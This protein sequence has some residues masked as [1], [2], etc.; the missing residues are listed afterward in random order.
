MGFQL[1]QDLIN[2]SPAEM[3]KVLE[4]SVK[5]VTGELPT[6][7]DLLEDVEDTSSANTPLLPPHLDNV[8]TLSPIQYPTTP[9]PPQNSP[10]TS[11]SS[12]LDELLADVQSQP[13]L[14]PNSPIQIREGCY[15][16]EIVDRSFDIIDCECAQL[17]Q[18]LNDCST[19]TFVDFMDEAE[20]AES[21]QP[22]PV[23]ITERKDSSD[24]RVTRE[25]SIDE[26][27][28]IVNTL[29]GK[30]RDAEVQ[31]SNLDLN[32]NEISPPI[33]SQSTALNITFS[34]RIID[35]FQ[36]EFVSV[37]NAL[38][39]KMSDIQS[40]LDAIDLIVSEVLSK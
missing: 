20:T 33:N 19:T 30:M 2:L 28:R 36:L 29:I 3:L 22:I 7:H 6:I 16:N 17:H 9:Y 12:F 32:R 1:A 5:L 27:S 14:F 13:N 25:Y 37:F 18:V 38:S 8:C 24:E 15:F 21:P 10:I 35:N 34:S 4:P 39:Q 31:V 23:R 11:I 40:R 26:L